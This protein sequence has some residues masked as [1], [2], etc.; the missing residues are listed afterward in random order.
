MAGLTLSPSERDLIRIVMAVRQLMEGRSNAVG[1]V[2][3]AASPATQTTVTSPTCAAG[4]V[5]LLSPRTANAAAALATTFV[6][7]GNGSFVVTHVSS[8]QTDRTFGWVALG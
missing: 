4:S 6:A 7:A 2:T 3:L 8:P 5:V 1:Q